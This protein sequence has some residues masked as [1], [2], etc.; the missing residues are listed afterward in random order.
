MEGCGGEGEKAKEEEGCGGEGK[1]TKEEGHDE[2][3]R[4]VR[5]KGGSKSSIEEAEEGKR[6]GMDLRADVEE[7]VGSG[8]G[9]PAGRPASCGV[10]V[11]SGR[12]VDEFEADDPQTAGK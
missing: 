8:G 4:D 12:E 6:R 11:G 9:P 7:S 1:K 5:E 10:L 2:E 3:R